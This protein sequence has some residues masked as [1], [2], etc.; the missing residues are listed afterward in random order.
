MRDSISTGRAG[1]Y[2][3]GRAPMLGLM[4]RRRDMSHHE[5]GMGMG[6]TMAAGKTAGKSAAKPAAKTAA[7]SAAKPATKKK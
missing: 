3:P 5:T 4:E 6:K 2:Y 1:A 7:K